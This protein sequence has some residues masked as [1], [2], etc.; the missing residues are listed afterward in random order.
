[1]VESVAIQAGAVANKLV[2]EMSGPRYYFSPWLVWQDLT[3][4]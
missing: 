3:E 2:V 1:M 4:L